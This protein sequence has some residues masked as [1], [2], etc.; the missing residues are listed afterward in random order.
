MGFIDISFIPK[1][2]GWLLVVAAGFF[3]DASLIEDARLALLL[4]TLAVFEL[5]FVTAEL[6]FSVVF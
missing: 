5:L 6:D 4:L 2:V 1:V 3:T